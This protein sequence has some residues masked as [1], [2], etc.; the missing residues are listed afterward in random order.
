[1]DFSG[2]FVALIPMPRL[3]TIVRDCE[4]KINSLTKGYHK[5]SDNYRFKKGQDYFTIGILFHEKNAKIRLPKILKNSIIERSNSFDHAVVL[6]Y[7]YML[8]PLKLDPHK[9]LPWG[10][11]QEVTKERSTARS[12]RVAKGSYDRFRQITNR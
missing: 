9:R 11:V 7:E 3:S 6:K 12:F 2:K 1:M 5:T 10:S 4:S 8:N